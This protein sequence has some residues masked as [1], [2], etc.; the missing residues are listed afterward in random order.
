MSFTL[1]SNLELP[2][3]GQADWDTP[4][5]SNFQ[6][7]ERG[8]TVGLVTGEAI[9]SGQAGYVNSAGLGVV[10]DAQSRDLGPPHF[11]AYSDVASGITGYFLVPTGIVRSFT[12]WSG[13]ISPGH[14]VFVDPASPGFL[15]NS[16]FDTRMVAGIALAD[17][18]VLFGPRN[19]YPQVVVASAVGGA[20][21]GANFDFALPIGVRGKVWKINVLADSCDAYKIQMHSN[22]TRASSELLYETATTSVDGGALDFDVSTLDFLDA[23]GFTYE[24]TNA[25]SVL[26]DGRITVQS[27][28]SVGSEAN[29]RCR[30]DAD[31]LY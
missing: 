1:D 28:S 7:L 19:P 11:L 15:V 29:F 21:A 30:I 18:A 20:L 27:A 17:D 22:S 4:L 31:R 14:D 25:N 10:Y 2:A 5:N 8:R 3:D 23:A 13:H 6:I 12:A 24:T 26:V 9:S 16:S